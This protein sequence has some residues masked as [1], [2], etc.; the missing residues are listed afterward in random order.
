MR[1]AFITLSLLLCIVGL[2]SGQDYE[3]SLKSGFDNIDK[4]NFQEAITN[5]KTAL[6]IKADDPQA[7]Y[8]L[9]A[10]NL[11]S[12]NIKEAQKLL[13]GA[14]EKNPNYTGF[15]LL[16]AIISIK[17]NDLDLALE[18]L[19]QAAALND[20]T[21]EEQILL[22]LG[23][24]KIR[25]EDYEGAISDCKSLLAINPSSSGAY[26]TL[27]IAYYKMD[28]YQD[29]I[30]NFDQALE[31][32][33]DNTTALYNRG[34]GEGITDATITRWLVSVGDQVDED[35]PIVEIATDKVDSEIPAPLAGRIAA[36]EFKEGDVAQ[37]GQVIAI[38]EVEGKDTHGLYA[39]RRRSVWTNLTI[40][41]R[42][43]WGDGSF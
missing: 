39:N 35:T 33:P 7:T 27:G 23:A 42:Q 29:A 24:L 3:T 12:D 1:K 37:V 31:I 20:K 36:I 17:K 4:Q 22:N 8:G 15:L 28:K 26:N 32:E 25:K 5:F 2:A 11:F 30:N 10:G 34:M 16:K 43:L 40:R 14:M 13:N 18:T 19:N 41:F 38:M 21:F 9:I 6:N